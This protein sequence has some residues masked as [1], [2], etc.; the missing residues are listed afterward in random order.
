MAA[1]AAIGNSTSN[2]MLTGN[3]DVPVSGYPTTTWSKLGIDKPG[4]YTL[5]AIVKSTPPSNGVW[6]ITSVSFTITP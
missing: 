2:G 1:Q 4:T 3:T 5:V 6:W